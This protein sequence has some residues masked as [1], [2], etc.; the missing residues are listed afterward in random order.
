VPGGGLEV[1]AVDTDAIAGDYT[2]ATRALEDD[3]V[4]FV[5]ACNETVRVGDRFCQLRGS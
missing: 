5:E 4:D 3:R 1:D 2:Q